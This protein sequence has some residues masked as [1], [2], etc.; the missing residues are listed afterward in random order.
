L[1]SVGVVQPVMAKGEG[2][3][4]EKF[5]T[6]TTLWL[7]LDHG[8]KLLHPFMP[9]VTEELWQ[10]LPQ[11]VDATVPPSIMV[12]DYPAPVKYWEDAAVEADMAYA[13]DIIGKVRP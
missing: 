10:R 11:P 12:A 4:A 9:F 5:A 3:E 8:L 6:R 7:A 1:D 2:S 13:Q